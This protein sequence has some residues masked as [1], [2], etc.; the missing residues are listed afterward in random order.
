ML[1]VKRN[2][3]KSR[4]NG[5]QYKKKRPYWAIS[6]QNNMASQPDGVKPIRLACFMRRQAD[7]SSFSKS[8]AA[9][10]HPSSLR[11]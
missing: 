1:K 9:D 5:N 8:M 10:F 6:Q 7:R 3:H 4:K 2:L 11:G